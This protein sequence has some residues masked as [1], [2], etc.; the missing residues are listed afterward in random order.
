MMKVNDFLKQAKLALDSHTV[1]GSGAFGAPISDYPSQLS[2]YYNNTKDR[3]GQ[4]YADKLKAEAAKAP[5]WTFDCCG[6]IKAI[7]WGWDAKRAPNNVYGG[8]VYESNGL[9]DYGADDGKGNLIYYCTDVSTDFSKI[10]P[11][12]MLWINGHVGIYVGD[13]IA[14]EC[15][16]GWTDN[17]LSSVVTNIRA[18]KSGERGRKWSKHGKLSKWVDYS[19]TPV[20]N[21]YAVEIGPFD[22]VVAAG[23]IQNALRALGTKST[24]VTKSK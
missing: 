22:T 18:A 16:T 21:K 9:P 11:G 23:D 1:Y 12:E 2:R 20:V 17:V 5:C 4:S 6:L 19:S 8:A 3:C 7:I 13:S 14:I 24:I 15:T 10:V